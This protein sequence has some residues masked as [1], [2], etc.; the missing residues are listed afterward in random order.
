M[1]PIVSIVGRSKSGKTT[2]IEKL[3][4]ELKARGY[5]IA[6]AK[7]T[8]RDMTAPESDKDSDRHLKA[9]SEAS[10]II[11]PHGL[12]MIK[13]LQNDI[14]IDQVAQIIGEDYDLILTEGFKEDD[15]PKIEVH[16]KVNAPP[17]TGI[18]KLFAVVTDEPLDTSVRQ[19]GL[20]DV[21]GIADLIETGF[22]KPN[23]ERFTLL[24]NDKP[25]ALN[26]FTKEFIVNIQ[27]AMAHG[28]KGV[29]KIHTLKIF[30]KKDE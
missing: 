27:L 17:L 12:M 16:R 13:P 18:K 25:I 14:A 5:H 23:K 4:V 30:L 22:L 2:L 15:A 6:T 3:I 1:P 10:M 26:A 9:G 7:H 29:D 19:F 21:Q 28:L 24:V 11:D 20:D 8:H